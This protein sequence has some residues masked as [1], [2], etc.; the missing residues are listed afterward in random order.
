VICVSS[1][2]KRFSITVPDQIYQD[3]ENWAA[4]EGRPT[5]Q[6]AGFLLELSVRA[7][8]PERYPSSPLPKNT[9]LD[10]PPT[11]TATVK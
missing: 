6:L 3:L 4:S 11:A 9:S 1:V 2:S 7:K 8:H 5:A 10:N